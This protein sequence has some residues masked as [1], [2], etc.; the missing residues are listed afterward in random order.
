MR[1]YGAAWVGLAWVA[2]GC[3]VMTHHVGQVPGEVVS[4][5]VVDVEERDEVVGPRRLFAEELEVS[6][7]R[8]SFVLMEAEECVVHKTERVAV[9]ESELTTWIDSD[10][11]ATSLASF[12]GAEALGGLVLGAAIPICGASSLCDDDDDE[13]TETDPGTLKALLIAGGVVGALG[14]IAGLVDVIAGG[15]VDREDT[16]EYERVDRSTSPPR[17]CH[18]RPVASAR[19]TLLRGSRDCVVGGASVFDLSGRAPEV[20]RGA[21]PFSTDARGEAS[22][23]LTALGGGPLDTLAFSVE[24]GGAFG[25][26]NP[27]EGQQL[28]IAR[29]LTAT[30]AP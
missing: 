22:I 7:S 11:E 30:T 6:G 16:R 12:G 5:E 14:I 15:V 20:C 17:R 21:V 13:P 28:A 25:L 29:V 18:E 4:Q 8:L 24:S 1:V 27:T 9:V 3:G 10:G 23:D 2:T 19:A 26:L